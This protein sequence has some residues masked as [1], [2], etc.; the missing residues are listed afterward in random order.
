MCPFASEDSLMSSGKW[1]LFETL[2]IG[3]ATM[4]RPECDLPGVSDTLAWEL[5]PTIYQHI[6]QHIHPEQFGLTEG[7]SALPDDWAIQQRD[8][9]RWVPGAFDSML[10]HAPAEVIGEVNEELVQLILDDVMLGMP[11]RRERLY[12]MVRNDKV[13][14]TL[15]ELVQMVGD[16]TMPEDDTLFE[17]AMWLA[18]ESRDREPVK[19]GLGLLSLF[20]HKPIEEVVL[21]LGRHDEFTRACDL[22]MQHWDV[23]RR[24]E[25]IRQLLPHLSGWGLQALV[26]RVAGTENREIQQWMIQ[27]G[28]RRSGF[29][30]QYMAHT[31]ATTGNLRDALLSSEVDTEVLRSAGYILS[32]LIEIERGTRGKEHRILLGIHD[33]ADGPVVMQRFMFHMQKHASTVFDLNFV[34]SVL[35]FLEDSEADWMLREDLGWNDSLVA[36]LRAAADELLERPMWE[37]VVRQGLANDDDDTYVYAVSAVN[38]LQL[39]EAAVDMNRYQQ[40]NLRRASMMIGSNDEL[41]DEAQQYFEK[42][43]DLARL[44]NTPR[45][46]TPMRSPNGY[47]YEVPFRP[48]DFQRYPDQAEAMI[49]FLMD[50]PV[51]QMRKRA[52]EMLEIWG[53]ANWPESIQQ[54]LVAAEFAEKDPQLKQMMENLNNGR[55]LND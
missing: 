37:D 16:A 48:E 11:G 1:A 55:L 39:A 35:G 49:A 2:Q 44:A 6:Q 21:V 15:N 4:P 26:Q 20:P 9:H 36:E 51:A 8:G 30:R 42:V 54:L 45:V 24:T 46:D 12:E 18:T 41:V 17:L 50:R 34:G 28:G 10:Q 52:L 25:V 27:D 47:R 53:E 40:I 31:L 14:G 5:P 7:G 33:Y 29:L 23:A 43:K 22:T 3:T 38:L 32:A 13:A 19:L